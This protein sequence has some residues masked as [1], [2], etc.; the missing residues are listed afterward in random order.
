[1][2]NLRMWKIKFREN[3]QQANHY[4]DLLKSVRRDYSDII[5]ATSR[6]NV[7]SGISTR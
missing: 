7:S 6:E 2:H 1:M 3:M 4:K 5:W